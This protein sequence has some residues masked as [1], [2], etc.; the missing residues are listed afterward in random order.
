MTPSISQAKE[1]AAYAAAKQ[2]VKLR[3]DL[4]Q[5]IDIFKIIEQAGIWLFFQPL[6][7]VQGVYL[8]DAQ[9][10]RKAILVNTRRPLSLQRLTAAHEYGHFVM[11]HA[12]SLDEA[13]DVESSDTKVAQEAAAQTFANDFLMPTQLVSTM[14]AS[15]GLPSQARLLQPHHAYLLSLYL[16]VSYTA[17]IYQLVALRRINWTIARQLAKY[18]PRQIKQLLGRNFGPLDSYADVWPLSEDDDGRSL[19]VRVNDEINIALPETPS[20]GYRWNI[21]SPTYMD[22]TQEVAAGSDKEAAR[23]LLANQGSN[24]VPLILI[25]DEFEGVSLAATSQA[26]T[27]GRRYLSL[28]VSQA[29]NT[30][31]QLN[32]IR[33]WQPQSP[34]GKFS[35]TLQA[36]PKATG[37]DA[38]GPRTQIK[39]EL[40]VNALMAGME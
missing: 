15:L 16:G 18:Q 8:A 9:T 20:S 13:I 30:Q 31:L 29:G 1:Q 7:D 34:A 32:L 37:W 21:T 4:S 11:G 2:L 38:Q 28:R 14:W 17:L 40:P 39:Q 33:P 26:G 19:P 10:S 35:I 3:L 12:A 24:R 25:S 5:P 23:V 36:S 6:Q 27:G 22:F